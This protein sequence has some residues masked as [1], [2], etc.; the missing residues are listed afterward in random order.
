MKSAAQQVPLVH[1]QDQSGTGTQAAWGLGWRETQ[2]HEFTVCI[3]DEDQ[4]CAARRASLEPVVRAAVNLDE[5]SSPGAA[6]AHGVNG[7]DTF[8]LT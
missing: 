5:L 2:R 1:Q 8:A 6:L 3:V 7:R 4:Q